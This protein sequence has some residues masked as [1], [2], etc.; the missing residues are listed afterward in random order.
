[1]SL[2]QAVVT[3]VKTW[4]KK[5]KEIDKKYNNVTKM[6][7]TVLGVT[8]VLAV[9]RYWYGTQLARRK[10]LRLPNGFTN[11]PIVGSALMVMALDTS[12]FWIKMTQ[13]GEMSTFSFGSQL[14]FGINNLVVW[15]KLIDKLNTKSMWAEVFWRDYI[16]VEPPFAVLSRMGPSVDDD[17]TIQFDKNNNKFVHDRWSWYHRRKSF[18]QSINLLLSKKTLDIK[19]CQILEEY[20]FNE[21]D[22][23]LNVNVNV[24]NYNG[25]NR[26]KSDVQGTIWYPR[27]W[28]LHVAFNSIYFSVFN[29]MLDIN[30]KEYIDFCGYQKRLL[31]SIRESQCAQ[32]LPNLISKL[33]FGDAQQNMKQ[34]FNDMLAFFTKESMLFL[35]K[36]DSINDVNIVENRYD[37]GKY[38][39]ECGTS[40]LEILYFKYLKHYDLDLR[41]NKL[42]QKQTISDL[43]ILF[44]G[45]IVPIAHCGE[46]AVLLAAKYPKIQEQVYQ[47]L[48]AVFG[49]TDHDTSSSAGDNVN[50]VKKG[51]FSKFRKFSLRKL[52]KC[53]KLRAFVSETIRISAPILGEIR[54]CSKDI[55]C[56]KFRDNTINKC[57]YMVEWCDNSDIWQKFDNEWKKGKYNVIYD[58][59]IR[60]DDWVQPNLQHFL[61]EDKSVWNLEK[62]PK[63]MNLNYWLQYGK[64]N[65]NNKHCRYVGNKNSI[66]FNIGSRNCVG[67]GI[68]IKQVQAF[69]G[70]LLLNYQIIPKDGKNSKMGNIVLYADNAVINRV[71]KE[72]PVRLIKRK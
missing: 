63:I 58:F 45:G 16:D 38:S 67:Q 6:G 11:L 33:M 39:D 22:K 60:K 14:I 30:S 28:T 41:Y 1:M 20:T 42:C 54:E 50:N 68:A 65:G 36:I 56:V 26:D 31:G 64:I 4:Y 32:A 71:K 72:I 43:M 52:F 9:S 13:M 10:K 34:S 59:V 3:V 2:F 48:M 69:V 49:D 46:M 70:N 18:S 12:S 19:L 61:I 29:K 7:L 5:C 53:P 35:D 27:N 55:R 15:H 44:I 66:P 21:I 40:V 23:K 47:E 8:S 24:N 51:N 62:N 17:Q 57:D 37:D 25:L